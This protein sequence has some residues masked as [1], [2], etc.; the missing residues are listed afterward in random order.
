MRIMSISGYLEENESFVFPS[1]ESAP[2]ED[3]VCYGGNASPGLLLSAYRQG[4]FPWPSNPKLIRWC[5]P[6][7]RFLIPRGHLHVTKSAQKALKKAFNSPSY[8][9]TLDQAFPDVIEHCANSPREGQP[10]TWIFPVLIDGYIELYRRGYAHSVEVWRENT[11]IGGLYGVSLG[12]A[13]F[14]ESMFSLES[15]AS[16]I[17]FI[18]LASTLFQNGFSFTDCQVYTPYLALMG[19]VNV[20]RSWYLSLLKKALASSTIKGNWSQTFPHFPDK[21]MIVSYAQHSEKL[22]ALN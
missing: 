3:V 22:V 8:S 15:N 5:S 20:P 1:P 6:N 2:Y 16:K 17:G 7:P 12:S 13:F 11:L 19:G 4:I 18:S 9:I 10:G 14:G 21:E